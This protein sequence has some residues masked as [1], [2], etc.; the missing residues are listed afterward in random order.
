MAEESPKPTRKPTDEVLTLLAKTERQ[1]QDAVRFSEDEARAVDGYLALEEVRLS[2]DHGAALPQILHDLGKFD[3][4]LATGKSIQRKEDIDAICKLVF[5]K[6]LMLG[7]PQVS[8]DLVPRLRGFVRLTTLTLRDGSLSGRTLGE[9]AVLPEL[10]LL[11]LAE[12]RN[13][14]AG[15]AT[16]VVKLKELRRF[17]AFRVS[18]TNDD[19]QALVQSPHLTRL[20]LTDTAVTEAGWRMIGQSGRITHVKAGGPD[21]TSA[22]IQALAV[23]QSIEWMDL[24]FCPQLDDAAVDALGTMPKLRK[25]QLHDKNQATLAVVRRLARLK[26]QLRIQHPATDHWQK[27]GWGGFFE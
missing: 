9:L 23:S 26:P 8:D 22:G 27:Y 4:L 12:I 3:S 19:V 2:E 20:G 17:H 11:A 15:A 16:E 25:V 13:W 21:V 7:G 18:I 1:D 24:R 5:L 14:E 10:H 6:T